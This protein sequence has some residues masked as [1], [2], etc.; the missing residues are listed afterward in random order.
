MKKIYILTLTILLTQFSFGQI[1]FQEILVDIKISGQGSSIAVD[2]DGDGV[3]DVLSENQDDLFWAKGV[4]LGTDFIPKQH[5]DFEITGGGIKSIYAADIDN[6]GDLD[7]LATRYSPSTIIWFENLNGLGYFGEKQI[8][9]GVVGGSMAFG[10]LDNDNDI[11]IVTTGGGVRWYENIDG[12]GN[13]ILKESI[14]PS[15]ASSVVIHDID[16]DND[17]DIVFATDYLFSNT[18]DL[19]WW[20]NSDGFGDFETVHNIQTVDN[21]INS[22]FMANINNDDYPDILTISEESKK[23]SWYEN[24]DGIGNFGIQQVIYHNVLRTPQSIFS[25]DIDND[26]DMDIFTSSFGDA[27]WNNIVNWFE[28]LDGLGNFSPPH[29]I[30]DDIDSPRRVDGADMDNDGDIDVLFTGSGFNN[31]VW[32]ENSN[33]QGSFDNHHIV[34]STVGNEDTKMEDIDGDGD[35]DIITSGSKLKWYKNIDGLGEFGLKINIDSECSCETLNINDIDGDGDADIIT[36]DNGGDKITWYKNID[37]LGNYGEEIIISTQVDFPKFV[38]SGDIDGD[39]DIDVLSTSSGDDKIAWYENIDGQ[40][41]F[42]PQKIIA[43]VD[44]PKYL[45][46]ADIDNDG[47]LDVVVA[48]SNTISWYEN[49]D[50]LGQ[51]STENI[52]NNNIDIYSTNSLLLEDLDNDDD[53][54]V[55]FVSSNN[56]KWHENTNGLGTFSSETVI[57]TDTE[58]VSKI[59]LEDM[60]DDDDLDLVL[61][62]TADTFDYENK[63]LAWYENIDGNFGVK[64]E[65]SQSDGYSDSLYVGDIDNDNDMD[66]LASGFNRIAWYK[67]LGITRNEINGTILFDINNNGCEVDDLPISSLLVS[68]DNGTESISTFTLNNGLY[69]LFP[70]TGSYTTT[71]TSNLPNYFVVNPSSHTSNFTDIGN[72]ETDDFCIEPISTIN[73]LNI[74]VYP[75]ENDPRPGFDTTYRIVY[76]NVGTTQ[77]NGDVILEFDNTKLNFLNASETVTS[78]T[79][80]TLTFNFTDLNPFETMTIDLELNVL[81]PP[82]TNIGDVLESTVTINPIS[83]DNTPDDN[84]FTLNQTVIG[85]YDPNDIA[86]LEGN[87]ILLADADKYLHYIIRFQNTGTASAI[88]VNV[89]NTLDNR[90]NWTTMQLESLS[91]TGRVEIRDGNE[92]KFIFNDI[93]LPDSTSDEPNSHGFIAYKI[94]EVSR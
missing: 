92:V 34:G 25:S 17:L 74:T 15:G 20:E 45:N 87:Q 69:Q 1:E 38:F 26:G 77:L 13:F 71:I 94:I 53:I 57:N 88:N 91:H 5:F 83:E 68:T 78:Q 40:G 43:I 19:A 16:M 33:G 18:I 2:L 90:L 35:L 29:I 86:V 44:Y 63:Y 54:D 59:A 24:L 65:I 72:T 67:N 49:L 93:N 41:S 32:F 82:T 80:N 36:L 48:Y 12:L 31:A 4:N 14:A 28:N 70:E 46:V 8:L 22:I 10:D 23:V 81:A 37:G 85:S 73:N 75:S 56:V 51:F 11:D 62:A 66:V 64:Q 58:R 76:R 42:G 47:D 89:E 27:I 60:D 55:V 50:G 21:N 7:I 79:A 61:S 84:V 3:L 6:D 9:T 52:V 30:S 39:G